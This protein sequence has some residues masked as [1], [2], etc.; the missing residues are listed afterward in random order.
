MADASQ[1]GNQIIL[2]AP[3]CTRKLADSLHTT[4]GIAELARLLIDNEY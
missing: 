2:A 1:H 4:M 3:Q